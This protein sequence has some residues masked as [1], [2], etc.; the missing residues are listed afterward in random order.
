MPLGAREIR[1]IHTAIHVLGMDDEAYRSLLKDLFPELFVKK[2]PTCK[3]LSTRQY[4]VLLK[5]LEG[6][7]FVPKGK[8]EK[9]RKTYPHR[10]ENMG[11]PEKGRLLHKVEAY[12]T[13]AKR[14]WAYADGMARRMF[15]VDKVKWCSAWQL[16]K[17]VAAL[18]YDAR[19]RGRSQDAP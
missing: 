6:K 5:D 12:L 1:K 9:G 8:P 15:K 17:I 16:H 7:G 18:E 2:D 3:A 11:D 14:A 10:P 19:R 13:E 4:L